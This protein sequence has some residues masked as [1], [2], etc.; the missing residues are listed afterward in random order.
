ME[1]SGNLWRQPGARALQ[2]G[3][4]LVNRAAQQ[5]NATAST[6][7][8]NALPGLGLAPLPSPRAQKNIDR[9]VKN[10]PRCAMNT[11]GERK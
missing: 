7:T 11:K 4:I 3:R 2:A 5:W 10:I 8:K 1:I 9:L 6:S